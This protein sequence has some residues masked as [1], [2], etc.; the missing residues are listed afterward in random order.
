M[1]STTPSDFTFLLFELAL[2]VLCYWFLRA[3]IM[4]RGLF[5]LC[6]FCLSPVVLTEEVLTEE[7]LTEEVLAKELLAEGPI[8][9]KMCYEDKQLLPYFAGEGKRVPDKNPGVSIEILR[10]LDSEFSEIELSFR[11]EPWKRCLAM[12]K[13]GDISGVIGSYKKSRHE[14]GV[15]PMKDG[16]PDYSR[17][18]EV[19]QYCLYS[20]AHDGLRW[21][22][23]AFSNIQRMPVAVALG[24]SIQSLFKQHNIKV[25]EVNSSDQGMLLLDHSR[26]SGTATLC[27]SGDNILAENPQY[28]DIKRSE[29]PLKVKGSYMIISHQ[30][31]DQ[32]PALAQQLWERIVIIN[33]RTYKRIYQLYVDQ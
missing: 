13:S 25:M 1:H 30:F 32:H 8:P 24:Y 5:I 31:Y 12:L 20:K 15:Y 27:E 21:D 22:G 29:I 6:L 9:F 18:F 23:R 3:M 17:A 11:R 26:V 7:V 33:K 2:Y 19:T 4:L 14:I 10:I 28:R 16:N